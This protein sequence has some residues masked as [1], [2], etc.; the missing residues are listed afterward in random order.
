MGS[1]AGSRMG[2]RFTAPQRL[3]VGNGY[4]LGSGQGSFYGGWVG[5]WVGRGGGGG[6]RPRY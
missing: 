4:C 3:R 1:D 6:T 2:R 5:G